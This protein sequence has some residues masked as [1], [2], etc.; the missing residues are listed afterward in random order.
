MTINLMHVESKQIQKPG[1]NRSDHGW[2]TFVYQWG[3]EFVYLQFSTES[4]EAIDR[5]MVKTRQELR[6]V[7]RERLGRDV[8]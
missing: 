5:K 6:R 2:L 1:S 3:S 7:A 8:L 4:R